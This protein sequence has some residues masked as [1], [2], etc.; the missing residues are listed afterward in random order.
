MLALAARGVRGLRAAARSALRRRCVRRIARDH[1]A[2]PTGPGA[3]NDAQSAARARRPSR[4]LPRSRLSIR[5]IY[6]CSALQTNKKFL[7]SYTV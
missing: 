7:Y 6:R 2:L 4:A 3:P 5:G 1:N